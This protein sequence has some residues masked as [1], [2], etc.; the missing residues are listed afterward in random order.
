MSVKF[1]QELIALLERERDTPLTLADI[2]A[3]A[4]ERSFAIIIALLIFPFLLPMIPG[5][6]SVMGP[7]CLLL[8]LQM[9][10]GRRMPWLPQRLLKYQLQ[11]KFI[12]RVLWLISRAV[13]IIEKVSRP[14][15][16]RLTGRDSVWRINGICISWLTLLLMLPVP[17]TNPI[18]S[19]GILLLAIAMIE[20]DGLLMMLGYFVVGLNTALFVGIAYVLWQSSEMVQRAL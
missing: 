19:V 7:A 9:A 3:E 18:P 2:L 16:G 6:S 20:M 8:S 13:K 11:E 17:F 10:W 14:R 5:A 15:W 4:S 1:S 12:D